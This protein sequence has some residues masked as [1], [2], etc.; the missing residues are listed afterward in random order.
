[1]HSD[2]KILFWNARSIFNKIG[3]LHEHAPKY[4]LIIIAE[5]WLNGKAPPNLPGFS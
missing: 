5:A 3:D 1:M 2:L 4:D